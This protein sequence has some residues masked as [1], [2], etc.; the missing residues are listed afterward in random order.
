MNFANF[1]WICKINSSQNIR[2]FKIH[3]IKFPQKNLFSQVFNFIQFSYSCVLVRL[4]NYQQK[5]L[6]S[7]IKLLFGSNRPFWT[8]KLGIIT[9]GSL[10]QIFLIFKGKR[11]SCRSGYWWFFQKIIFCGNQKFMSLI[12]YNILFTQ[13]LFSENAIRGYVYDVSKVNLAKNTKTKYFNLLY[14]LR[15]IFV[16]VSV[17][18]LKNE[19]SLSIYL[20][21]HLSTLV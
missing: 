18:H 13:F 10:E 2:I 20:M 7:F 15:K 11:P 9:V 8:Q 21:S 12:S 17:F 5:T 16:T 4:S 1:S 6:N 14:K 19:T 3:R